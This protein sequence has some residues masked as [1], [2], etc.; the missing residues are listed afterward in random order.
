MNTKE[1]LAKSEKKVDLSISKQYSKRKKIVVLLL[2]L[3]AIIFTGLVFI[4]KS[5]SHLSKEARDNQPVAA[6]VSKDANTAIDTGD[7]RNELY[8]NPS[9]ATCGDQNQ[10]IIPADAAEN[11]ELVVGVAGL[12]SARKRVSEIASEGGG[13]VYSTNLNY[14]EGSLQ[15][16]TIVVQ[17]PVDKFEKTF[18]TLKSVGTKILRESTQKITPNNFGCPVPMAQS[19]EAENKN[20]TGETQSADSADKTV[21]ASNTGSSAVAVNSPCLYAQA[22]QDKAYIKVTFIDNKK[23]IVAKNNL[24]A[25]KAIQAEQEYRNRAWLAFLIKVVFLILL[26]VILVVLIIRA[27]RLARH[28]RRERKTKLASGVAT[29]QI[30]KSRKVMVKTKRK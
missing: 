10:F 26:F 17:V 12:D 24:N 28:A 22:L 16:G 29:R 7:L 6:S 9:L 4:A 8:Q 11:G 23:E 20:V 19:A 14:A 18:E 21:T 3:N 30:A 2:L 1:N 13:M 27:F 25:G 15:R 5:S